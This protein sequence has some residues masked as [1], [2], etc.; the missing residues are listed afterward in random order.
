MTVAV[1]ILEVFWRIQD[2]FVA[3]HF[4]GPCCPNIVIL[5]HVTGLELHYILL[6]D[7]CEFKYLSYSKEEIPLLL[8]RG[9]DYKLWQI[10]LDILSDYLVRE[11]IP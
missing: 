4:I 11:I 1:Y 8:G 2:T 10:P 9:P 6:P 5:S 7:L 3:N